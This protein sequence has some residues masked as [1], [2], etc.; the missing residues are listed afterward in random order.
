MF[1][2][3]IPVVAARVGRLVMAGRIASLLR[4]L[5]D[6]PGFAGEATAADLDAPSTRFLEVWS[7]PHVSGATRESVGAMVPYLRAPAAGPELPPR[8]S[9]TALRAGL[10]WAGNP[11]PRYDWDR[12]VPRLGVLDPLLAVEGVEWVSLQVG[13]RAEEAVGRSILPCP[14]VA[15]FADTAYLL[16]QLDLVVTVDSAVANLAGALG[17]PFWLFRISRP[18]V[19]WPGA[20]ERS[21]WYPTARM[22]WRR[23][24]EDWDGVVAEMAGALEAHVRERRAR[25]MTGGAAG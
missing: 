4:L 20:G 16:E 8:V 18:E 23:T 3:F 9:E 12:S 14:P 11:Q 5:A 10:V 6:V 2:R 13:A 7:L 17:R 25:R 19:R 24:T 22:F 21:F 1:A 15:D